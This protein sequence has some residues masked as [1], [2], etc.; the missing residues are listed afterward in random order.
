MRK[1]AGHSY[2]P[3]SI[4]A[5]SVCAAFMIFPADTAAAVKISLTNCLNIIIPSLFAM[6]VL[7]RILILSGLYRI[8]GKPFGLISR[9][10]FRIPEE[11][12]P[13]FLISQA[14]G[15]PVGAALLAEG[16]K[17]GDIPRE[18]AEDM[19]GWCF[20]AGPAFIMGTVGAGVFGDAR[21]G[22]IIFLS[23]LA[24]NI[25]I[26][27]ASGLERPV[28][29]KSEKYPRPSFTAD[30]INSSVTGGGEAVLKMCA[31]VLFMSALLSIP[32][33]LGLSAPAAGYAAG[34][35]GK[36]PREVYVLIRS[37][38]EITN[39]TFLRGDAAELLPAAA[40]LISFGGLSVFMQISAVCEGYLSA[41][42][43]IPERIAAAVIS[44]FVCELLC[45]KFC[46]ETAVFTIAAE[47]NVIRHNPPISSV[48]LLI[49][50]I[51]L[52]SQKKVVKPGKV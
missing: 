2:I 43:I 25:L 49:M 31:A 51:L 34:L 14:A 33:S 44:H 39:I 23:C 47:H 40:A 17:N 41:A 27:A 11:L 10:I 36:D 3:L 16:V 45:V 8:I 38:A 22:G 18:R 13:I 35:L 30:M 32:E 20:G 5:A 7:S 50:T 52:L 37:A 26:G 15:Y 46:T 12:F 1:N 48:F 4:A 19:L 21:C 29:A 28:P 9:Y 6:T 24:A 42:K